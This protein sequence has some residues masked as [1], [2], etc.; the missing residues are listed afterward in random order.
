[1]ML[2]LIRFNHMAT[3]EDHLHQNGILAITTL[4]ADSADDKLM[5]YTFFLFFL[6]KKIRN[7]MQTDSWG[8]NLHNVS[9][10]IFWEK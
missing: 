10:P 7:F 6:A 8:D 1:M 9:D 2:S 5:T 4:R 3:H